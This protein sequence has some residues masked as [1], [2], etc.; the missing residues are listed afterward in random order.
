MIQKFESLIKLQDAEIE[1]ERL[2]AV[3]SAVP[4]KISALDARQRSLQE[5]YENEIQSMAM[6]KKKYR[7]MDAEVQIN[8]ARIS[9]SQDKLTSVKTNKEYQALLKAIDDIKEKNSAIE[10]E[11]IGCLEQMETT[12]EDLAEKGD[13]LKHQQI[14]INAEKESIERGAETDRQ[15]LESAQNIIRQLAKEVDATLMADYNRVKNIVKVRALVPVLKAVCQGCHINIPP[16]M[17][18]ELQRGDQLKFCPH[19]G[20]IIFWDDLLES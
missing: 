5:A 2:N 3:L 16:Q 12:E 19:C 15:R 8:T 17:F 9:K 20:R 6:L 11:M 1:I 7:E 4:E 14:Q 13:A 10:D 18:N